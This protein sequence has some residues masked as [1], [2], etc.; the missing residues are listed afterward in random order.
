MSNESINSGERSPVLT[1]I[2]KKYMSGVGNSG[3]MKEMNLDE[4]QKSHVEE[5]GQDNNQYTTNTTNSNTETSLTRRERI[6]E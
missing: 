1:G 3:D 4:S 6:K 2:D 5:G